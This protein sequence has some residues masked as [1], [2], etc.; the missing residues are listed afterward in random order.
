MPFGLTPESAIKILRSFGDRAIKVFARGGRLITAPGEDSLAVQAHRALQGRLTE[1]SSE[2][3]AAS[4]R[5]LP[6]A[7]LARIRSQIDEITPLLKQPQFE[8]STQL[9]PH[10]QAGR[11]A[12]EGVL[13][14]STPLAEVG[15]ARR[16]LISVGENLNQLG[17]AGS[18][19][20]SRLLAVR[21]ESEGMAGRFI[22]AMRKNLKGFT[23]IE[24]EELVNALDLGQTPTSAKVVR[25]VSEERARLNEIYDTAARA[26]PDEVP[27]F[28]DNYFPHLH[29]PDLFNSAEAR[30]KAITQMMRSGRFGDDPAIART[31]AEKYLS[32]ALKFRKG[33][34]YG[35]LE[36]ERLFDVDGWERNPE[37]ALSTYYV[38]AIRRIKEAEH[39]GAKDEIADS[40]I[41]N[42]QDA[43][44]DA[45]FARRNFDRFVGRNVVDSSIRRALN[46]IT[47]AEVVSKLG[48]AQIVNAPQGFVNTAIQTN[49]STAT[50]ALRQSFTTAGRDFAERSG[51]LLSNSLQ[52]IAELGATSSG[53]IPDKFLRLSGFAWTEAQNRMVA[54]LGGKMRAEWAL[55]VLKDPKT[56]DALRRR[57]A[58]V[59]EDLGLDATSALARGRLTQEEL[60][61]AGLRMSNLTQFRSDVLELPEFFKSDWG[62]L[63]TQFKSF[64]YNHARFITKSVAR[65]VDAIRRGDLNALPS[66]MVKL[67]VPVAAGE[68]TADLRSMLTGR[69]RAEGAQR[70][71]ENYA[72]VGGL[73]IFSDIVRAASFGERG[74][75]GFLAGPAVGDAAR[76]AGSLGQGNPAA[77]VARLTPFIGGPLSRQIRERAKAEKPKPSTAT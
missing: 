13:P 37:K 61:Q 60:L 36:R 51:A 42:I 21:D 69:E 58:L 7:Q 66:L 12:F 47:G 38:R 27:A 54:A 10:E 19:L 50:K 56:S 45:A 39:L 63:L 49:I 4:E 64:A 31:K 72:T 28:R 14:I 73:G 26:L 9:F 34:R 46:F 8:A 3:S 17:P 5:G 68:I 33:R 57:A 71:V 20:R 30:N 16:A 23:P 55:D 76:I 25:A 24:R 59:F 41:G 40:L 2:L 70:L 15:V 43:G 77:E 62:R 75:L 32:D 1:L 18:E 11:A 44:G 48:L 6:A 22:S 53:R 29:D 74:V 35:N 52:E 67:G 65:D